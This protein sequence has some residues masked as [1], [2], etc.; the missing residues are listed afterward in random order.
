V[1]LNRCN[2]VLVQAPLPL[3]AKWF[4]QFLLRF[5]RATVIMLIHDIDSLRYADKLHEIPNEMKL[6]GAADVIICHNASMNRWLRERGVR[7]PIVELTFFDYLVN[8]QL[9]KQP[10]VPSEPERLDWR[11][12]IVFAGNLRKEKSGF[13]YAL[14]NDYGLRIRVFGGATSSMAEFPSCVS[15]SG[16]FPPNNP[17]LPKCLFGL[18]WDGQDIATCSGVSGSYLKINSPHKVSLYLACGMPVICW[19]GSAIATEIETKQLGISVESLSDIPAALQS[20]TL[21]VYTAMLDS[22]AATGRSIRHGRQ[23]IEA[24]DR[25]MV[26]SLG[27]CE[28]ASAS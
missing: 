19:R 5:H 6:L 17:I 11:R 24:L 26:D 4:V 1:L 8:D 9:A 2:A 25:A 21:S 20:L 28:Y 14:S 18:V 27:P 3:E 16:H 7:K 10:S 22:V 13:L 15:Y 12:E 23:L